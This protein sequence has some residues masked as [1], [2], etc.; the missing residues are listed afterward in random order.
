MKYTKVLIA[1]AIIATII[2]VGCT[3]SPTTE[4]TTK[5]SVTKETP[6]DPELENTIN[7]ET[8]E[9]ADFKDIGEMI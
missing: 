5:D 1:I 7:T 9:K 3:T 4:D 6:L 8:T 2:I